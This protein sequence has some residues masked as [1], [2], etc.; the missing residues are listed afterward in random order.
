LVRDFNDKEGYTQFMK[1]DDVGEVEMVVWYMRLVDLPRGSNRALLDSL[2]NG[3]PPETREEAEIAQNQVNRNFLHGTNRLIQARSQWNNAMMGQSHYFDVSLDSGPVFKRQEWGHSIS[4]N[5]NRELKRCRPQMEQVRAEG[6]QTI[7]HGIAPS[8]FKDRRYPICK[9]IPISSL[10]IPSETEIDFE[11]LEYYAIFREYTPSQLWDLTHGPKVDPGWNMAAVE[12]AWKYAREIVVKD[13]N[14]SAIQY[15]PERWEDLAKQDRGYLG[16]DAAPTI[17]VWDFYFRSGKDG[18]GWYRRMFL[19][20]GVAE[21]TITSNSPK[22]DSRNGHGDKKT[23][24]GFLYTSGK[25][26]FASAVSEILQC[27]FGDCSAVAP[28]KYHSVRSLGWLL[29]GVCDIQN[30]MQCRFTENVFMQFLWWFRVAGKGD[31]DRVKKAMFEN[32]GVIPAGISMIPAQERFKPDYEMVK[33]GFEMNQQIMDEMSA[34]FTNNSQDLGKEETATAT[35]AKVHS[36][37]A[38]MSGILTLAYEYSKYKWMETS[39][40]FCIKN[41]PY[42]MAKDFQL[43]C[44]QDGVPPEMLDASRWNIEPDKAIGGGNKI[45]E[46][47][48]IQFLQGIRKNLGPDAQRKVDHMSIVSATDQPALAEDLAPIAGQKKL[49]PSVMNAA[50]STTRIMAGLDFMPSPEMVPEDYVTVWL[51]D[52]GTFISQIQQSGGVG[53]PKTLMGLGNLQKNIEQF[54]GQMATN[55]DDKEK[56]REYQKILTDM[57]N[58]IKGFAQRL[59]QQQA[60]QNGQ[61]GEH[62]ADQAKAQVIAQQGALKLRN[63]DQSHALKTAQKITSFELNEQRADRK[64]KADIRRENER[65]KQELASK[66]IQTVADVH[67]NRLKS[68]SQPKPKKPDA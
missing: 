67:T 49:A 6:A 11:N 64:N 48:I 40:R 21:D 42:K 52:M 58:H 55:E 31:F 28:F 30:R 45:L 1:W 23:Y 16:S 14:A 46:M 17:D 33:G 18:E 13:T 59:Q 57:L 27:Q 15:M 41:N 61:G 66:M 60:K 63:A 24:G 65:T 10:M 38:L 56:V 20:W 8:G 68:L 53:D 26:K 44:L 43:H 22:P 9:T 34:T 5:I 19:D 32:M 7:L 2:Y 62:A 47:A 37:N 51:H 12:A 36:I 25:R 4:A 35:M 3:N 54:L 39:R 29:W 50:E